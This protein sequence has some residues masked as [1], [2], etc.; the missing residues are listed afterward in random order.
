[1]V[2]HI[3]VVEGMDVVLTE[4]VEM[5]VVPI[6]VVVMVGATL[7]LLTTHILIVIIAT[8]RDMVQPLT[9]KTILQ[10]K[11]MIFLQPFQL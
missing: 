10:I 4:A 7:I 8:M 3:L 1:M 6:E 5:V 9:D 11:V 2:V